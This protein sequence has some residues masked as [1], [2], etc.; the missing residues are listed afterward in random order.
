MN[1]M[2]DQQAALARLDTM[3]LIRAFE[4]QLA[5]TTSPSQPGT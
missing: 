5:A 4:E 1:A 2:N 3:L